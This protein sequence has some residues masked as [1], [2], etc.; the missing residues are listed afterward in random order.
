M[1]VIEFE[2]PY[3]HC[4]GVAHDKHAET[5]RFRFGAARKQILC[6]G[7]ELAEP[8]KRN[9][10]S[11]KRSAVF[12]NTVFRVTLHCRSHVLARGRKE[13]RV[14]NQSVQKRIE[15]SQ[16]GTRAPTACLTLFASTC[17]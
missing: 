9:N 8:A 17:V 5:P 3:T 7:L 1:T 15:C 12:A 10:E 6:R 4:R 2:Q 11:P 16:I 14:V 13:A